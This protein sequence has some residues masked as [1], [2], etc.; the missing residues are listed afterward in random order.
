MESEYLLLIRNLTKNNVRLRSTQNELLYSDGINLAQCSKIKINSS[1]IEN[2]ILVRDGKDT[3]DCEDYDGWEGDGKIE[4]TNISI[5]TIKIFD[6]LIPGGVD[7][8]NGLSQKSYSNCVKNKCRPIKNIIVTT[9]PQEGFAS[10][11]EF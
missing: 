4:I 3:E 7:L 11:S 9:H 6:I 10:L 8:L 2:L 5:L 1:N